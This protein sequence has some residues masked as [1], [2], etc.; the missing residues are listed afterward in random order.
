M[1]KIVYDSDYAG[2]ISI[3]FEGHG[4]DPLEGS[5]MTKRLIEKALKKAAEG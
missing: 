4:V 1:L 2:V 3:E 5:R